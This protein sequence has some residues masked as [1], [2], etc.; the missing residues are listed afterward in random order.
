MWERSYEGLSIKPDCKYGGVTQLDRGLANYIISGVAIRDYGQGDAGSSPAA[1][2]IPSH[3]NTCNNKNAVFPD[4]HLGMRGYDT[5][6][7]VRCRRLSKDP[8]A[9]PPLARSADPLPGPLPAAALILGRQP[10]RPY[11]GRCTPT[12][13]LPDGS[14]T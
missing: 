13:L 1:A 5:D 4:S 11:F 14:R 10:A 8:V 9:G 7:S 3:S 6:F 2:P 12:S